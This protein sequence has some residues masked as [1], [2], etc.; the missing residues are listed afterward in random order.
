MKYNK[1]TAVNRVQQLLAESEL[2]CQGARKSSNICEIISFHEHF[3]AVLEKHF[4]S[5]EEMKDIVKELHK[6]E[7]K[8]LMDKIIKLQS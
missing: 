8:V 4:E 7:V 3:I 6:N 2:N 1:I 5:E